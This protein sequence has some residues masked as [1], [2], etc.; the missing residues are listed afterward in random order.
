VGRHR[1]GE[2]LT[3][4]PHRHPNRLQPRSLDGGLDLVAPGKHQFAVHGQDAIPALEARFLGG[5]A[6]LHGEDRQVAA[7]RP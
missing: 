3:V 5:A 6:G 2:L 4:A 7:S 1:E